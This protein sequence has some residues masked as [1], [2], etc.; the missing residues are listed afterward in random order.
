MSFVTE[1][2]YPTA[3]S[4]LESWLNDNWASEDFE[5]IK[6]DFAQQIPDSTS[7]IA[8]F[9]RVFEDLSKTDS[10]IVP[11][12]QLQGI[13]WRESFISGKVKAPLYPD[14]I[15]TL[16]TLHQN[17]NVKVCI[18]SSGSI[19]AQR[20]CFAHT[21][22]GGDMSKY[23]ADYFDP[24]SLSVKDKRQPAAY[25]TICDRLTLNADDVLFLSDIAA[26][27]NAARAAGMRAAIVIRPGNAPLSAEDRGQ[28]IIMDNDISGIIR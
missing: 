16:H 19:A 22:D 7:S 17:D 11:F 27:V 2:L 14:V 23:I 4:E 10:K 9:T 12:K 13:L 21:K 3:L 25:T 26:E 28:N 5:S 6:A 8:A 24:A 20:L 1:V 15:K 18:F